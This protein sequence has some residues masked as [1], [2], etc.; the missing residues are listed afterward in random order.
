MYCSFNV[1]TNLNDNIITKF[2]NVNIVML[3]VLETRN[4]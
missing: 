4:K 2:L 3:W 1:M